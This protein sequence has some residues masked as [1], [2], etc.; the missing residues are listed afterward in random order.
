MA[1]VIDPRI[2]RVGIEVGSDLKI[3]EGLSVWITG[4]KYAN[5]NQND[6]E[7]KIANL[8]KATR[9]YL[10]TETSPFNKSPKKKRVF[11][12]VG[13]GSYGTFR[14]FEGDITNAVPS[15]PPDVTLSF[16]ALT[17]NSTKGVILSK[18]FGPSASLR[19]IAASVASTLGLALDFRAP[20]K[21]VANFSFS[22]AAL[23]LV[24]RLGDTGGV[25][26]FIDDDRL[27]VKPRVGPLPGSVRVLDEAS[28][29]VGIP[30][31]TEKGV[32]VKFLLDN[33]TTL[34]GSL[35][36]RSKVYPTLSGTYEIFKLSFDVSSDD[37]P[38]YYIAEALRT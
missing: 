28:G 20:D 13:R 11:V 5:A 32:K 25:S 22:G 15:Q 29:L 23:R 2:V 4:T 27:V 33:T 7:I 35:I 17:G 9:D 31:A 8:D 18:A 26:A 36:L 19:S 3:Y 34:G 12:D 14:L 21:Q 38:F 1:N 6:A 37:T 16:K 10:I 24:D 30:E